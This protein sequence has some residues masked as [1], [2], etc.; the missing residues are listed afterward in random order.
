VSAFSSYFAVHHLEATDTF[1][2]DRGVNHEVAT[3]KSEDGADRD[4]DLWT[5]CFTPR[6]LRLMAE[7]AGLRTR[8]LWAVTPGAY[9]PN[10]PD[11][12]HPEFLLVAEVL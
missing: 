6:E 5:T 10:P 8:D 3:V 12:D 7:R 4:F 9:A 2:A 11:L 1:D